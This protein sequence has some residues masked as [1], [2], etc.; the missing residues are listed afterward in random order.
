M[1]TN[2]KILVVDDEELNVELIVDVLEDED[3]QIETAENGQEAVEKF[4]SFRPDMVLLD[5][6]MPVM[7]GY[8]ACQTIRELP[9]EIGKDIPIIFISAKA[10]LED[11][12]RGYQAGG[13]DYII[14]PFENSELLIKIDLIFKEQDEVKAL[15]AS[16]TDSHEMAYSLMTSAAKMGAIGEFLRASLSCNSVDELLQCFF[17]LSLSGQLGCT[18]KTQFNG[19]LI[20]RSDDG[21]KHAID[22]ELIRQYSS[23][24]RIYYFG[25]NRALFNWNNV[26]LLVRNVG[27]EADHI[28]I[29]LDGLS[30]ALHFMQMQS[31]L[32][33][34]IQ[35]LQQD[36]A[37][38]KIKAT[39]VMED[40]EEDL[41]TI[42][43]ELGKSSTLTEHEEEQIT[44]I[45][46]KGRT[47]LDQML[48][49]GRQLE[50]DLEQALDHY[51]NRGL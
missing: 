37:N 36:N 21:L 17:E 44:A 25:K 20:I 35:V 47:V 30:A 28:A 19:E 31:Q 49:S 24:D 10:G 32:L 13:N 2:Y 7:D 18:L 45:V 38:F 14:K 11:K 16:V 1:N 50:K 12:V 4:K 39:T 9:D 43:V 33:N 6:M 48:L 8:S 40:I 34:S 29:M 42:F 46:E 3:Y 5:V 22:H 23:P 15:Q 51:Q 41:R 27:A 26:V